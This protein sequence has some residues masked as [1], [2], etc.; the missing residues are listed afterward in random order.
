[1]R[2]LRTTTSDIYMRHSDTERRAI[3]ISR[4]LRI[5]PK[6]CILPP[7]INSR[8]SDRYGPSFSRSTD[9]N[10]RH[11]GEDLHLNQ[12]CSRPQ[13]ATCSASQLTC[14]TNLESMTPTANSG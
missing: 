6:S 10:K 3:G 1:M 7:L 5:Y 14:R 4:L 13:D 9:G 12:E 8:S 11:G 2:S